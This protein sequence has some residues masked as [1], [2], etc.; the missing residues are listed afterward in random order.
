VLEAGTPPETWLLFMRAPVERRRLAPVPEGWN[1]LP[2]SE[3]A[4]LLSLS[5]PGPPPYV[6]SLQKSTIPPMPPMPADLLFLEP[7]ELLWERERRLGLEEILRDREEQ[8]EQLARDLANANAELR[9]LEEELQKLMM[10]LE[11]RE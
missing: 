11:A 8:V 5:T 1:T 2:P 7:E 9:A 3:L 10:A 4:K 6:L